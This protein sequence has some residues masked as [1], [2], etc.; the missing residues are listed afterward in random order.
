[1]TQPIPPRSFSRRPVAASLLL[2]LLTLGL[3]LGATGCVFT[4]VSPPRGLIMTDQTAPL[5]PG[6]ETGSKVG[7]ASAHNI[8]FLFGWG[9]SG[10]NAAIR[11][12]GLETV[13]H[14]DYR[15]QNYLLIYQKYT[16]IVY[17]E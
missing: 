13:N 7:R 3:T 15:F 17:G 16:T 2:L 8:L 4:T 9:D 5:F 11:D 10:L 14:T 12:G 6:R 1:M